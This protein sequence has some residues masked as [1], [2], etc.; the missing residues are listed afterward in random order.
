MVYEGDANSL[1]EN[2]N[3][4][5]NVYNNFFLVSTLV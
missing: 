2:V 4:I 3:D 1:G 5:Q